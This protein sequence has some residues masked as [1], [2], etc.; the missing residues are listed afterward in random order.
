V[1]DCKRYAHWSGCRLGSIRKG[2][3]KAARAVAV[4][5]A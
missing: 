3:E 1:A 2:D 5:D 4:D